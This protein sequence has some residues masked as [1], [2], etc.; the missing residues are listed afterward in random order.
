MDRGL[1]LA[2]LLLAHILHPEGAVLLQAPLALSQGKHVSVLVSLEL[3][4]T[5]DL[6]QDPANIG[7]SGN[8][9]VASAE[10]RTVINNSV[11]ASMFMSLAAKLLRGRGE[12]N[13]VRAEILPLLLDLEAGGARPLVGVITSIITHRILKQSQRNRSLEQCRKSNQI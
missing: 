6:S 9:V 12:H 11:I 13:D 7:V 1:L 2:L 10:L 5:G 4:F 3:N 8:E